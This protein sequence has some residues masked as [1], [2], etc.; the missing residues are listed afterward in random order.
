MRVI[1]KYFVSLLVLFIASCSNSSHEPFSNSPH[2]KI[3]IAHLKTLCR[4]SSTTITDDISIEAFVVANDLFGEY[5]KAIVICDESGG[6]ELSIDCKSTAKRFPISARL[7]IHCTGLAIGNYG[8][9]LIIG[10]KPTGGY[11]I[12]R[13]AEKDIDRYIRIDTSQPKEITP[14]VVT[15][16]KISA[17]DIGNYIALRDIT[18][19]DEV[20]L[21]WCEKDPETDEFITTT[22]TM[23]DRVGNSLQ[24][25]INSSCD[26]RS[27]AIPAGYGSVLG[28]LEYFNDNYSLRI[29][30]HGI[31]F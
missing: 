31:E 12:D 26:Y 1:V 10:A 22:H 19:G 13:I 4:D 28:I 15:I 7:V 3:S 29:I 20:G 25:R 30:N 21:T 18:F 17:D 8:G 11:T 16:D 2:G 23:F 24:V 6:I 9:R 27:E 5:Q 14:K